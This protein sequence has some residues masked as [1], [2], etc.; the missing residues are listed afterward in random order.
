MD[1]T[2]RPAVA[3]TKRKGLDGEDRL[4]SD[5]DQEAPPPNKRTSLGRSATSEDGGGSVA[6]ADAGAAFPG[7]AAG[8][9]NR[10]A[11]A[12]PAGGVAPAPVASG[13]WSM[14][15]AAM[16]GSAASFAAAAAATAAAAS[17]GEPPAALR[18]APG[19]PEAPT[20]GSVP[21]VVG[22]TSPE[23]PVSA[24]VNNLAVSLNPPSLDRAWHL[25]ASQ[26]GLTDSQIEAL[27][28]PGRHNDALVFQLLA[29]VLAPTK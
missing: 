10:Q 8:S 14:D 23:T 13:L 3:G 15:P 5:T 24:T 19:D 21:G 1:P 4:R 28:G 22:A 16:Q 6:A 27:R 2:P 7:T 11:A 20:M 29:G 17:A 25:L 9:E 26:C 18:L 12:A